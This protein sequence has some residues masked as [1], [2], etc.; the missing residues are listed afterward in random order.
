MKKQAVNTPAWLIILM[1]LLILPLF[2]WPFIM[3]SHGF[4][5]TPSGDLDEQAWL[6]SIGVPIFALLSIYLAYRCFPQRKELSIILLS[7]VALAYVATIM[8][9]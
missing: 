2:S 7:L 1:V 5:S 6:F 8:M 9:L 4:E 3:S